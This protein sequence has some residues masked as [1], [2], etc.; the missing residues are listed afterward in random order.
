[1]WTIDF[2]ISCF[3]VS[4]YGS[5]TRVAI[6][7][8]GPKLI[9]LMWKGLDSC[10]KLRLYRTLK[11]SSIRQ[12]Y[13]NTISE[14]PADRVFAVGGEGKIGKIGTCT[15]VAILEVGTKEPPIIYQADACAGKKWPGTKVTLWSEIW[16]TQFVLLLKL[17]CVGTGGGWYKGLLP[18]GVSWVNLQFG[19]LHDSL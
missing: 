3:I 12:L 19:R 4:H 14:G 18:S 1:M 2:S 17:E 15:F 7:S 11:T 13:F 16:A 9:C 5:C 6:T 10:S 8:S